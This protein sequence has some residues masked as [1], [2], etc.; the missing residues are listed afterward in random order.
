MAGITTITAQPSLVSDAITDNVQPPDFIVQ[1]PL[2]TAVVYLAVVAFGIASSTI[3]AYMFL[4]RPKLRNPPNLFIVNLAV[5]DAAFLLSVTP[6][7]HSMFNGGRRFYGEVGCLVQAVTVI[8]TATASLLSMGLI[9]I[10]RY[11]AIVHPQKKGILTWRRCAALCTY[12]WNHAILLMV[13][14]LT[15]WGRIGWHP[16]SWGCVYDWTYNVWYNLVIFISSQGMTAVLLLFCYTKIYLTYK[17]SK[18]RVGAKSDQSGPKKEEIRLAVQFVVIFVIYNICWAPLFIFAVFIFPK[19]D[20]P[21]WLYA[22]ISILVISNS[23]VNI[24][25]YLFFNRT[26]RNE[27]LATIGI[28]SPNQ[29]SSAT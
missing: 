16:A 18:K 8:I 7:I 14:G 1:P 13:P 25:V 28:K 15:G 2:S 21:G 4:F 5:A 27:C 11:V 19:G 12:P 9:A 23:A 10:S 26:F 17:A 29:V 24:L 20:A 22:V 3:I 6:V